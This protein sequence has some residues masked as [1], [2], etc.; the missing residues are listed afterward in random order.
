MIMSYDERSFSKDV[1]AR[2][3][4]INDFLIDDADSLHMQMAHLGMTI[5]ESFEKGNGEVGRKIFVFLENVLAKKDAI[6]EIE[7][8][9]AISFLELD[10]L[11]SLGIV[12]EVPQN[13]LQIIREQY[14]RWQRAT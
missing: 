7:N 9:V 10:E 11:Q 8:A 13:V 3:G 5:R 2:W 6:S 14:K 4:S 1:I 12:S